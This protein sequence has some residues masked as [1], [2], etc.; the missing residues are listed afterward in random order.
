MIELALA[1]TDKDGSYVEHAAVVLSSVFRNTNSQLNI[2]ILH[3]ETLSEENKQKLFELTENYKHKINF[4]PIILPVDMLEASAGVLSIA[5]WTLGGMYRLLLPALISADRIIYMDCDVIVNMDIAQL[6]E[7]D[8]NGY[9][10][11]AVLDP[12]RLGVADIVI[13]CGLNPDFYFNSGVIL[14]ALNNIRQ[15]MNWYGEMLN[16]LRNYPNMTM[17]DQDILNHVFGGN[18]LQLEER[19]NTVNLN[20]AD[21]FNNKIIHSAGDVKCWD[22][23]SP[24]FMLYQ[25]YLK[26]KPRNEHKAERK[27]KTRRRIRKLPLR[28]LRLVK[29]SKRKMKNKKRTKMKWTPLIKIRHVK[30]RETKKVVVHRKK[31]HRLHQ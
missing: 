15:N 29:R 25:E 23:H 28:K 1:F 5:S 16:F 6:W 18:Y 11:G 13:A 4:Y 7:T 2:H 26:L 3:D 17:P 19:F 20:G 14:F 27:S 24:A 8:L 21:D 12:G 30:R 9:Y 10:L 31:R 22:V